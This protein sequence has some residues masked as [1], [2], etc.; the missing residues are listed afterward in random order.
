MAGE[1]LARTFVL[2]FTAGS[3][4][5]VD[6]VLR[7]VMVAGHAVGAVAVP[8]G[9]ESG[10]EGSFGV[11][12]VARK[13]DVMERADFFAEAARD[14]GF[15][16]MEFAVGDKETVEERIDDIAVESRHFAP[17]DIDDSFTLLDFLDHPRKTLIEVGELAL[18]AFGGVEVETREVDIRLGHDKREGSV[19]VPSFATEEF[20]EAL[21]GASHI[22][23]ASAGKVDKRGCVLLGRRTCDGQTLDVFAYQSGDSPGIDRADD[24]E[25][26]AVTKGNRGCRVSGVDFREAVAEL[27]GELGGYVMAVATAGIIEEHREKRF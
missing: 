24:A 12:V 10:S 13:R 7:A 22:V 5:E 16:D 15:G 8:Y 19:E 23:T 1:V 25:G 3:P 11:G 20:V 6:G 9:T 14:A 18:H 26:F 27:R 17:N 2:A 21:G 4:S